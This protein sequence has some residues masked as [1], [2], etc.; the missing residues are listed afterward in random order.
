MQTMHAKL[1]VVSLALGILFL[2]AGTAMAGRWE[3][4]LAAF[5]LLGLVLVYHR[6]QVQWMPS[7]LLGLYTLAAAGGLLAGGSPFLLMVGVTAALSAWDLDHS[8]SS[9]EGNAKTE[10]GRDQQ[11]KRVLLL[12]GVIGI[13]LILTSLGLLLRLSLPFGAM[14]FLASA[15]LGSISLLAHLLQIK[16]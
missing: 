11:S 7:L 12:A 6:R 4:G 2:V 1:F 14:L 15:A 3:G 13:S 8:I 10:F 9:L 5:V 16:S